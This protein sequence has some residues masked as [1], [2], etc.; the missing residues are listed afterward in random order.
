MAT[1][2][3]CSGHVLELVQGYEDLVNRRR[4]QMDLWP[5]NVFAQ[6]T[7]FPEAQQSDHRS[8]QSA[9]SPLSCIR[10]GSYAAAAGGR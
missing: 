1:V 10:A 2:L 6:N 5:G 8:L 4:F 7:L 9:K 3:L